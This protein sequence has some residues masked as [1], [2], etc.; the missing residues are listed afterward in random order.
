MK[1]LSILF[2]LFF[3]NCFSQESF[4]FKQFHISEGLPS[5]QVYQV[6]QDA[7]GYLWFATDRG[8]S[9]Y[10]GNTFKTF[11]RKEGLTDE[12]V[13]GFY[14]QRNGKLWFYTYT[15]GICY[16]ENGK[17]IEPQFNSN[18]KALLKQM[19]YPIL[20]SLFVNENGVVW[21]GTGNNTIF[22][23]DTTGKVY[24]FFDDKMNFSTAIIKNG[25]AP[26]QNTVVCGGRNKNIPKDLIFYSHPDS[27]PIYIPLPAYKGK[28]KDNRSKIYTIDD[29]TFMYAYGTMLVKIKN[30]KVV[31][32]IKL[33][34]DKRI[35]YALLK[36]KDNDFW[37]GTTNG[38]FCFKGGD[39]STTP[40]YF[41]RGYSISSVWQD[42]ER[43]YW[44][45]SLSNGVFYIPHFA[46]ESISSNDLKH[47]PVFILSNSSGV[48]VTTTS[49]SLLY[50]DDSEFENFT[51]AENIISKTL[52]ITLWN[53]NIFVV[54]TKP[55]RGYKLFKNNVTQNNPVVNL[56]GNLRRNDEGSSF[57]WI[58]KR[59]KFYIYSEILDSVVKSFDWNNE[60]IRAI[61][62]KG[63]LSKVWIGTAFGLKL[64]QND[65]LFNLNDSIPGLDGRISDLDLIC[66]TILLITTRG[67]GVIKH[68]L[69]SGSFEKL[70]DLPNEYCNQA[71]VDNRDRVWVTSFSGVTCIEHIY[72]TKP[73]YTHFSTDYGLIS[74]EAYQVCQY[75]EQMWLATGKGISKWHMDW[76]PPR[77][78]T[79]I[80]MH[81]TTVNGE[82]KMPQ[83]M[84][85]LTYRQNNLNF[86]F[87]AIRFQKPMQ[88]QYRLMGLHANWIPTMNQE[89]TYT[90]LK[91]GKYT[92]E[93][94]ALNE[95][96]LHAS[97]PI[98]ITYPF[99]QNP[100][101]WL[102][103]ALFTTALLIFGL[104]LRYRVI[105]KEDKLYALFVQS[106]QKALRAQL[107]PHFL[108]NAFN[109]IV[110]LLTKKKYDNAEN[111]MTRFSKLMRLILQ[112]SREKEIMLFEEIELLTHYLE[113][114]KLRFGSIVNFQFDVDTSLDVEAIVLPPLIIQPYIENAIKH[115]ILSRKDEKGMLTVSFLR[116]QNLLV[117]IITDNGKGYEH[118]LN[119]KA[120]KRR[121]YG[122]KISGERI[123][124]F[125]DKKN[126]RVQI[127]LLKENDLEYPGTKVKI[128][129]PYKTIV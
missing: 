50:F 32:H 55:N 42:H 65:S 97:I 107:N 2:F 94:R 84:K 27:I 9:Q 117:A 113:L 1:I 100:W 30:G 15:G 93:L 81:R 11:T 38:V 33:Q 96:V 48:F 83:E 43:G 102:A 71:F 31:Q 91:P 10:D 114:E 24:V 19:K 125:S 109:S 4:T 104:Q 17:I 60:V 123:N 80:N 105:L 54:T 98:L 126:D 115:G 76:M 119:Q 64:Y 13:F 57:F 40:D 18:F 16:Y 75:K 116:E 78:K 49:G 66:D 23:I 88:Y 56:K 61:A 12:V 8:V 95:E 29:T 6:V 44:F 28:N 35:L 63:D 129:L 89:A 7:Q 58:L 3:N 90:A 92:F 103:V 41:L 87:S 120:K 118:S 108:F 68:D 26:F 77:R 101:F 59:N 121:S 74:N 45:T 22:K 37:V 124:L 69:K 70:I 82:I 67:N 62:I 110:E 25:S 53:D 14:P 127:T 99:W 85:D 128:Y 36:D 106:E 47:K 79:K 51:I 5:E 39:L 112:S 34:E 73:K 20:V 21:V 72:A 111:Y 122:M 52:P 86:F 46:I